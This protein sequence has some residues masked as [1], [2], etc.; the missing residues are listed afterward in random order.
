MK[1]VMDVAADMLVEQPRLRFKT[2]VILANAFLIAIPPSRFEEVQTEAGESA[3]R[4]MLA[5]QVRFAK[6]IH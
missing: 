6:L 1:S 2:T 4:R 5:E 3:R